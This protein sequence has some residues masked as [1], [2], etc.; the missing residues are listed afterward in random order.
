MTRYALL[1]SYLILCIAGCHANHTSSSSE[2]GESGAS[3]GGDS[4]QNDTDAETGSVD[5]N[6]TDDATETEW[7]KEETVRAT[8][9]ILCRRLVF[10]FGED[11]IQMNDC[12]AEL[13]SG[14]DN[15]ECPTFNADRVAPCI[16]CM[17]DRIGCTEIEGITLQ[18][19]P[20]ESYCP[21]CDGLCN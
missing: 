12:L 14:A 4:P 10:C 13:I 15:N 18:G 9:E 11:F 7:T 6:H 16:T 8:S 20:L 19:Y 3:D 21:I 17:E 2:H 1:F 5:G